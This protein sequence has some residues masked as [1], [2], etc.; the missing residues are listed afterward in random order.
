MTNILKCR[1]GLSLSPLS[2]FLHPSLTPF[3]PP[4]TTHKLGE[5]AIQLLEIKI[6]TAP[7]E[8]RPEKTYQIYIPDVY[9]T[10]IY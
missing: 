1:Q 7:T 3:T 9:T 8:R 2:I 4:P 6:N 10:C 5:E